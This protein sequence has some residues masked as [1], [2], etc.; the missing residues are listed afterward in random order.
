M[1]KADVQI[2]GH[3]KCKVTN[4]VVEVRI[5]GENPHGGWDAVNL[6]TGKKV[7]IK[8]AQRLRG[9]A[10]ARGKDK[11]ETKATPASAPVAKKATGSSKKAT[12]AK[13]RDTGEHVATSAKRGGKAK[14]VSALDA[15]AQV[16]RETGKP[17]RCSELIDAMQ[18]RNL[19][20]SPNGKTPHAT[21]YAA[22]QREERDKGSASRFRKVDRGLFT[23]NS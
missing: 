18:E 10:R 17:M 21:L 8:S 20:S 19:W 23:F 3:Y 9:R 14:R 11:P 5:T 1:K 2:G 4:E 16:L 7:R 22:M 13:Q 6:K 12:P 15:A